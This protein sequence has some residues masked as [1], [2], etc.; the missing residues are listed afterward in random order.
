M[1]RYKLATT[2]GHLQGI[3]DLQRVNLP[4]SISSIES[5]EQGFVTC[6]H[7]MELLSQMNKPYPHIIAVDGD[8][9]VGYC[10]VMLSE[11]RD[12]IDILKPMFVQIDKQ[13][14]SQ[15]SLTDFSYFVMG[16]VCIDKNYRGQGLFKGLYDHQKEHMSHDFEMVITEVSAHNTRSL[17]AHKNQ[18][19]QLLKS[20]IAPDGHPWELIYWD[21]S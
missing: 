17:K 15:K 18:G 16:Q 13:F 14:I 21:W 12:E 19:F 2:E 11:M 3:L 1:V 5:K 20:Y 7:N 10:L 4:R 8:K 9:V 6:E